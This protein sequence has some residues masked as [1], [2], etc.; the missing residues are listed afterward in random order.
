MKK[1]SLLLS[2]LY[3]RLST[4]SGVLII[5]VSVLVLKTWKRAKALLE[6]IVSKTSLNEGLMFTQY[7][8]TF[9]T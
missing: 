7:I 2:L 6:V 3:L 4:L 8:Y 1:K 9:I 5:Q